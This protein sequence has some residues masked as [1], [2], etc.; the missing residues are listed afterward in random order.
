MSAA[1]ADTGAD[2]AG[3]SQLLVNLGG[4]W[5]ALPDRAVDLTTGQTWRFRVAADGYDP[6]DYALVVRPSQAFLEIDAQLEP[7]R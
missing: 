2:L 4:K 7:Q 6:V 5:V 1:C 3:L